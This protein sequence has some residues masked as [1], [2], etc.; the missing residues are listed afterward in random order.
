MLRDDTRELDALIGQMA[1]QAH[2]RMA[3]SPAEATAAA[4]VNGRL[5]RAGMGVAT[6]PLRVAVRPG[7]AYVILGALGLVAAGMS[8][9]L[10]LPSLLL[11]LG[12]LAW[13]IADSLGAPIPPIGRR[14]AS[15]TIIGVR[16]I[17]GAAGLAPRA[18]RWRVV[19]LAP[20]DSA[21]DWGGLR[22]LAGPGRAGALGR[23]GAAALVVAGAAAALLLPDPWWLIGL[24][25]AL[26]SLL[27]A[28]AALGRPGPAADDGGLTALA[29]LLSVAQRVDR[30]ATVELWAAAVGATGVDPRGL[31]A[32]LPRLPFDRATTLFISL[33]Q[34]VGEQLVFVTR[35]GA[36]GLLLELAGAADAADP[37]IDAEPRP[38]DQPS[39]LAAP[40]RRH[41]Y[42]TLTILAR[43]R[44]A[45]GHAAPRRTPAPD[46]RLVERATRLVASIIA[47][48]ERGR[49]D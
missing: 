37:Q 22:A 10:A 4:F 21:L 47:Q 33:E 30:L 44:G 49:P 36:D 5:R 26:G 13:L 8:P 7:G 41:G 12:V 9:L 40:L 1:E 38:C 29:A 43:P 20:L 28:L 45:A 32:L 15:Q 35:D 46:P 2:S 31:T 23:I 39:R 17:E 48:L 25:G 16:A 42:R 11:A 27:L 3:G 6:Y 19:L 24:P 14:S 18:P 34:L